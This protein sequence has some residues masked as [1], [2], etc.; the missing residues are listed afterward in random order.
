[1]KTTFHHTLFQP[2]G[3]AIA[4][5]LIMTMLGGLMMAGWITIVH[6]RSMQARG[7]EGAARRRLAVENSRAM[8]RQYA[9]D[10]VFQDGRTQAANITTTH[11]S[12]GTLWG[13]LSTQAGFNNLQSFGVYPAN[14]FPLPGTFDNVFPYNAAGLRPGHTFVNVQRVGRP[15][16]YTDLSD[17]YTAWMFVKSAPPAIGGDAFV[18]YQRPAGQSTEINLAGNL[19][20]NGRLV[21]RDVPSMVPA[22]KVGTGTQERVPTRA[23]SFYIQQDYLGNRLFGTA[24]DGSVLLSTNAPAKLSSRGYTNAGNHSASF[25]GRLNVVINPDNPDNSLY[26]IQEREVAAGNASL[27]TL[28]NGNGYGTATSAVQVIRYT[29]ANAASLPRERHPFSWPTY[30]WSIAYIRLN[31]A[32]L[33]H[34]RIVRGINQIIFEGQ[35]TVN[36]YNAA[37]TKEP[38]IILV[39]LTSDFFFPKEAFFEHENAR[40]IIY[41]CK[42]QPNMAHDMRW[43]GP[44]VAG[45]GGSLTL[46]WAMHYISE[47]RL[48]IVHLPTPASLGVSMVGGVQTDASF[49]RRDG[50][51]YTRFKI[52]PVATADVTYPLARM[53]P[54]EGW[55]ETYFTLAPP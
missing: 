16:A 1:V 8:A 18:V 34:I 19:H 50:G 7:M 11:S 24:E 27:L 32:D 21:I 9:M 14:S 31:H 52:S 17:P 42:G 37:K 15:D 30:P 6:A 12:G 44:A 54:R 23:R 29:A 35:T 46:D 13:S 5:A 2:R 48:T 40:P 53:L 22:P 51:A 38:R 4:I 55:L 43:K 20:I 45:A 25:D 41:A 3:G 33:P 10:R 36:A 39:D 47:A 49:L 28:T 26:H